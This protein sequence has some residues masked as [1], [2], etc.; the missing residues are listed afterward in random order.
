[1]KPIHCALFLTILTGTSLL[2]PLSHAADKNDQRPNIVFAIADD[3]SGEH[4]GV[5]GCDWVKTPSFDRIANEGVRFTNTF[6]SN[7]KC[8]PCRASILTGR[9]SWQLKEAV[10]HFTIF[11]KE[12]KV[13]PTL[14]EKAG[15][16]VGLTGKGWGPGDYKISGYKHNPA[17]KE[18]QKI[19]S[20]SPHRGI[21]SINYAANFEEFLK[22]RKKDQPFCFWYGAYEPHRSYE[23]GSGLRE[24]KNLKDVEVPPYF[25]DNRTVRSDMLDYAVEV[26]WFDTHL[27]RIVDHLEK[28]GELENTLI[29][30]TSDHGMPFPRVKGQ[31]LEDGFHLPLAVRWGKK[32]KP[33]RV[34]HDF[35]NVRD[36]AP[37][38]MEAAGLKPDPQMTGKSFMD[39]LLSD[40]EGLIDPSRDVH[41]VGKER[42]DIGRP[43]DV[44]YPVRAIRTREFLYIRNYEADR[45]PAGNPET[46]YRNCDDSPTKSVILSKF[47]KFYR[48]SFGK[49][50]EEELYRIDSD[51]RCMENLADNAEYKKEI[52]TLRGK[53]ETLLKDE[54]DPRMNG[55]ASF[56]DTIEYVGRKPHG[57][58]AWT[59]FHKP[60][61]KKERDKK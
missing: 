24:G 35:I 56:F 52:A 50:P 40:K 37:T 59:E 1:M 54:G 30:V 2:C 21:S 25:P 45:W 48:M 39:L 38:I 58:E 28:I 32:V 42:H 46:G 20:K 7:P 43:N 15:Y 57:W 27:G 33:G 4:A 41:L 16:H 55:K 6:T 19:K 53:M 26:E 14:M 31:I 18:Y 47:D 12:F 13:Y 36:Y 49:R 34:I 17:G 29:I 10:N 8:S 3:W 51:P 60:A 23:D 9:N 5:N 61:N 44:G 22:D 11:P